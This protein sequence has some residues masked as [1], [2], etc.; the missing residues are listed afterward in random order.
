MKSTG[1]AM[2]IDANFGSAYAKAQFGAGNHLPTEGT[3]FI[4]VKDHDKEAAQAVASQF[5]DMGFMIMA[6]RGTSLFLKNRGISNKMI[7]KVSI[8]RPHVVDAVKNKAIQMI[9]NTGVGGATKRDG[10]EI[11]RAAIKFN[12]PYATTIAGAMAICKGIAALK[13]KRLSVK[14]IQEYNS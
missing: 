12:I 7:N 10:Y 8:G 4:S 14:T 3:V 6:T 9:I 2:G 1:E 11:R 5:C 13:K